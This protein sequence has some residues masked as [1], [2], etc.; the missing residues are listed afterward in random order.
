MDQRLSCAGAQGGLA[1]ACR[2]RRSQMAKGG[3][4]ADRSRV[5]QSPHAEERL[6]QEPRLEARGRL[7]PEPIL[8]DALFF[9]HLA[10]QRDGRSA[11]QP[12]EHDPK[13]LQTHL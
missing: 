9:A 5:I 1:V 12:L 3:D 10:Q 4:T 2:A 11:P 8:R 7:R 13:K 6:F